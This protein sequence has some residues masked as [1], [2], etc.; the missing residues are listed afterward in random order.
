ML[1]PFASRLDGRGRG[2]GD[3]ELARMKVLDGG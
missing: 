2:G 1:R 3:C